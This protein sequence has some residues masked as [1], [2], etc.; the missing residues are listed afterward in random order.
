MTKE[1]QPRVVLPCSAK[2]M[3]SFLTESR[4]HTKITGSPAFINKKE[5]GKFSTYNGMC[6]GQ[7]I[8]LVNNKK[9]VQA[10][11]AKDWVKG[12]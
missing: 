10:W 11:R 6:S 7:N 12:H 1:F 4:K 3:F 9:L 2:E 5:G 8:E